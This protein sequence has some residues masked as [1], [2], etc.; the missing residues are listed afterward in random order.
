MESLC[1]KKL[2]ELG[3]SATAR[4][5]ADAIKQ[6][7]ENVSPRMNALALAGEIRDSGER[8]SVG[9]GRPLKVWTMRD[10]NKT[11]SALPNPRFGADADENNPRPRID[12]PSW[13]S[14]YG[15]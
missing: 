10:D 1:L 9:R 15:N 4:E 14:K 3:G 2:K 5:I 13:F 6:P 11:K 12:E 7:L 8:V